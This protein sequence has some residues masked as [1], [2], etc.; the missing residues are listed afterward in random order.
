MMAGYLRAG[1]LGMALR[2]FEGMAARDVI[3]WSAMVDGL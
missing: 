3:S 1:E 2:V